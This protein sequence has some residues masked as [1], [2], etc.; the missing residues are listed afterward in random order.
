MKHAEPEVVARAIETLVDSVQDNPKVRTILDA[1]KSADAKPD[2]LPNGGQYHQAAA[3]HSFNETPVRP[4]TAFQPMNRGAAGALS[5]FGQTQ[6]MP[7]RAPSTAPFDRRMGSWTP[8]SSLRG[9]APPSNGQYQSGA[10]SYGA[11]VARNPWPPRGTSQMFGGAGS[12]FQQQQPS[13]ARLPAYGPPRPPSSFSISRDSF[14]KTPTR[15]GRGK[16]SSFADMSSPSA[17]FAR[18]MQPGGGGQNT[19]AATTASSLVG[20][21][22]RVSEQNVA[23]WNDRVME[24]YA[25]IRNFVERHANTPDDKVTPEKMV[26]TDLWVVLTAMYHPLSE[27]EAAS[28]LEHHLRSENS[29]CCLVTR[30]IIDYVVNRVWSLVGWHSEADDETNFALMQLEK[31][32]EQ[33]TGKSSPYSASVSSIQAPY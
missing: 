29:K 4:P 19:M 20:P 16:Y 14:P 8:S 33:S 18:P 5:R 22:I 2:Q 1:L 27:P 10:A 11:M 15:N 3:L 31:H 24:F 21:I 7:P 9:P 12:D 28:Y 6:N 17:G 26:G 25:V 13:H 30:V 23:A 32:F